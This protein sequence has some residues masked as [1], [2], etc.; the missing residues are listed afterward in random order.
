MVWNDRGACL[1]SESDLFFD[2]RYE[3]TAKALCRDC[4]VRRE[5]LAYAIDR[6]DPGIWGGTN[7][8]ERRELRGITVQI[9]YSE[10]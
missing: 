6:R 8:A 4:K 5:C 2:A 7:V 3:D 9:E 10:F 1:E